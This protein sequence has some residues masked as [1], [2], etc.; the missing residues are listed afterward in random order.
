MVLW[1]III[2]VSDQ[3]I[4]VR[5]DESDFII[6]LQAV[7]DVVEAELTACHLMEHDHVIY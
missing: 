4:C 3:N 5:R 7:L 2:R 6:T 1:I